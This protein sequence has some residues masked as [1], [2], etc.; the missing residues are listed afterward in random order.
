MRKDP[1]K[2]FRIEAREL[3]EELSR[4]TLA[5]EQSGADAALVAKLLR[6]AHTLKGAARVVR[7]GALADHAHEIEGVLAPHRESG[8]PLAAE[9]VERLLAFVSAIEQGVAGLDAPDASPASSGREAVA[10]APAPDASPEVRETSVAEVGRSRPNPSTEASFETVRVEIAEMDR[11]LEAVFQVG[12][13][14][15]SLE[16]EVAFLDE[17]R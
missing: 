15:T 13:E 4:G 10:D 11:L 14:A 3:T 2:Y 8:G 7:Q 6:V 12:V 9:E 17:P 1:Y 5:L 16:D